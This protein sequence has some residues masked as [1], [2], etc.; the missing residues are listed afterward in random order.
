MDLLHEFT[1]PTDPDAALALLR[2][3]ERLAPCMPGAA[4]DSTDGNTFAGSMRVKVGAVQLTY[5]GS[6]TMQDIDGPGRV[7]PIEFTATETRGA[8]SASARVTCTVDPIDGGSRVRVATAL[9]ITGKPAQFGR[10]VINEI[11]D[12]VVGTFADNLAQLLSA[13]PGEKAAVG[14][15]LPPSQPSASMAAAPLDVL[16][17]AGPVLVRRL[18]P[19]ATGVGGLLL[20]L[21]LGRAF[22]TRQASHVRHTSSS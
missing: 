19:V 4:L 12:R 11:G 13:D 8:G 21:L 2:D 17:V 6:G 22:R 20:G 10:G 9:D 14:S 7:L 16:S 15:S 5:R 3:V 1:V 18:L